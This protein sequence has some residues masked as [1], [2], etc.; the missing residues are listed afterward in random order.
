MR[1]TILIGALVIILFCIIFV[2]GFYSDSQKPV[3]VIEAVVPTVAQV[4]AEFPVK[5]APVS[6]SKVQPTVA[7]TSPQRLKIP[8]IGVDAFV[9][10]MG[11]TAKGDMDAPAGPNNAGWYKYGTL[12]GEIGSAVMDGHSGWRDNIPAIFDDLGNV[13]V[14]DK[15]YV[16]TSDGLTTTFVV[17]EI[18][19]Y[20]YNADAE[21]I[22]HSSDGLSHLNLITC[23]GTW[24]N[25]SRSSSLRLVVF[26]DKE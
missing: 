24:N 19:E 26:A 3:E 18:K 1:K 23:A 4:A 13:R 17:R 8:S 5:E 14:G 7:T 15:I 25:I 12:P 10:Q 20:G 9:E 22:F 11:L 16:E 6:K 21:E 2:P